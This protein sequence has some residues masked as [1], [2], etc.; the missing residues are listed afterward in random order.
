MVDNSKGKGKAPSSSQ[1]SSNRDEQERASSNRGGVSSTSQSLASSLRSSM[2]ASQLGSLM[3]GI[4]GGKAEFQPS[5]GS[6]GTELRDWLVQDLRGASG[7][8]PQ[9][10]NATS[11]SHTQA[12]RTSAGLDIEQDKLFD[13][14]SQG[15]VLDKTSGQSE[16][17][18]FRIQQDLLSNSQAVD[19]AW[20]DSVK[21]NSASESRWI[22]TGVN[23]TS[24]RPIQSYTDFDSPLHEA[25]RQQ[26][27]PQYTSYANMGTTTAIAYQS[28]SAAPLA[29]TDDIFALLDSEQQPSEPTFTSDSNAPSFAPSAESKSTLALTT[30]DSSLNVV[31]SKFDPHYRSPSPSNEGFTREQATLHMQLAKAQASEQ[32]RQ[33]LQMP[34]P[35]N[36]TLQEGVYAATAL[37]ALKSVFEGRGDSTRVT[38]EEEKSQDRSSDVVR[39]ITKYFSASTY[40]DDV[41]GVCPLLRETIEEAIKPKV[42]ADDETSAAQEAKRQKAIQRLESLWNHLSNKQPAS[43]TNT[44]SN[45]QGTEWVDSWLRNNT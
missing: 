5:G 30:N 40:L 33:E 45:A 38:E 31:L 42:E 1:P 11:R 36:P 8:S 27:S 22:S 41:Y 4:S 24:A 25:V 43:T 12:F 39:K 17:A 16:Q 19:Q 34:R 15:L 28:A 7:G 6:S 23:P 18:D 3:Q 32:G 37:E 29:L 26:H 13:D 20:K 44:T 14:F 9:A 2:A 21:D 10:L 35:D